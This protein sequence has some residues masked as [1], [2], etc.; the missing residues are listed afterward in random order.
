[1][2]CHFIKE[3][4]EKCN[5]NAMNNSQFCF[6]HN[7]EVKDKKKDAVLRGGLSAKK[8]ERPLEPMRIRDIKDLINLLEDTIN[9]VRTEPMTHQKANCIGYLANIMIKA[10]ESDE[11]KEKVKNLEMAILNRREEL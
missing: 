6:T 4:N 9:K 1:M 5:A 11:L 2:K 8:S 3:N 10:F 7:P